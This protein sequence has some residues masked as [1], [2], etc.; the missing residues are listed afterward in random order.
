[1][2]VGG[3]QGGEGPA[4]RQLPGPSARAARQSKAG[5]RA[6]KPV[7]A[8]TSGAPMAAGGFLSSTYSWPMSV[9]ADR[10]PGLRRSARRKYCTARSWKPLREGPGGRCGCW[11]LVVGWRQQLQQVTRSSRRARKHGHAETQTD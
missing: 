11:L 9:Q 7:G 6:G 3:A 2:K 8:E 1:M 10:Y 5:S 4:G